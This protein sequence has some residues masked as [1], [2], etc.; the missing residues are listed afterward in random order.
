MFFKKK[1]DRL[2]GPKT[3]GCFDIGLIKLSVFA[4]ALFLASYF[5]QIASIELRWFWLIVFVLAA[6]RPLGTYWKK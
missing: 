6:I 4:F 2:F 5:P 1:K 3:F